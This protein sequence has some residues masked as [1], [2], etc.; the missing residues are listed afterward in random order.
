M[1]PSHDRL[2]AKQTQYSGGSHSKSNLSITITTAI[3]SGASIREVHDID[4]GYFLREKRKIQEYITW[5][6]S[7]QVSTNLKTWKGV[8]YTGTDVNT[9]AIADWLNS[10]IKSTRSFKQKQLYVSGPPNSR[11][12]TLLLKLLEYLRGYE[13]P[14]EVFYDLYLDPEPDLCWMDEYKGQKTIQWLNLFSQGAPM[15]LPV[16]GAQRLKVK[17]PPLIIMSNLTLE[18]VYHKTM[19]KNPELVRSLQARFLEIFLDSPLD[20]DNLE[21]IQEE[22]PPLEPAVSSTA[23]ELTAQNTLRPVPVRTQS[24]QN[25]MLA[26]LPSEE[27]QHQQVAPMELEKEETEGILLQSS[28]IQSE[29]LETHQLATRMGDVTNVSNAICSSVQSP[30]ELIPSSATA[31]ENGS[32]QCSTSTTEEDIDSHEYFARKMRERRRQKQAED[33]DDDLIIENRKRKTTPTRSSS[34]L[35]ALRK[36][37]TTLTFIN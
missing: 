37:N 3:R 23:V 21:F 4:P 20:L 10:N 25:L 36:T 11:K 14:T 17:N 31:Q 12:T 30:P 29:V 18:Q 22:I 16:K 33:D 15:T 27:Q 2:K 19:E 32:E 24:C 35:A 26:A 1:F 13:I 5:W 7:Q 8:K 34:R 28:N 9:L 6:L